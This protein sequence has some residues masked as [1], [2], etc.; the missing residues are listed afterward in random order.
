VIVVV[1]KASSCGGGRNV[2][3]VLYFRVL[4]SGA[5]PPDFSSKSVMAYT[6]RCI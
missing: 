3:L 2:Y 5:Q 1:D 6:L 4:R